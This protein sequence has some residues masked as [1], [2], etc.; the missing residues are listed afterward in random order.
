MS[1]KEPFSKIIFVILA[2]VHP[3]QARLLLIEILYEYPTRTHEIRP[4]VQFLLVLHWTDFHINKIKKQQP[5]GG[6]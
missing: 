5:N 2:S 4:A 3:G 6:L 1:F